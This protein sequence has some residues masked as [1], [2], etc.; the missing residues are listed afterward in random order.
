MM[1]KDMSL[2]CTFDKWEIDVHSVRDPGGKELGSVNWAIDSK[3]T[4]STTSFS[5]SLSTHNT[6]SSD[7]SFKI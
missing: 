1:N 3:R 7:S 4:I 5:I 6:V 2:I